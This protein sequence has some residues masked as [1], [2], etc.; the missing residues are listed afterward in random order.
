M[1]NRMSGYPWV[2]CAYASQLRH[3]FTLA[4]QLVISTTFPKN[5]YQ[6]K[7]WHTYHRA[8]GNYFIRMLCVTVKPKDNDRDIV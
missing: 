2:V 6:Q 5:K 8:Y 4:D 3:A 7:A 1:E